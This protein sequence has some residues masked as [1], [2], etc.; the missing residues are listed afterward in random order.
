MAKASQR[1]PKRAPA[2]KKPKAANQTTGKATK[3]KAAPAAKSSH[4]YTVP[5]GDAQLRH[6]RE[7]CQVCGDSRMVRVDG[8]RRTVIREEHAASV[9]VTLPKNTCP[10]SKAMKNAFA[11]VQDLM[12]QQAHATEAFFRQHQH[13]T[14]W[15]DSWMARAA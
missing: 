14:R 12:G 13:L 1:K 15:N 6:Q 11:Q 3:L 5:K 4:Q 10:P 8:R 9:G 2:P 7:T